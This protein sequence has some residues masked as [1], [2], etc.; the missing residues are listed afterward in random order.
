[1]SS[2]RRRRRCTCSLFFAGERSTK[3]KYFLRRVVCIGAG[4]ERR[5]RYD[6]GVEWWSQY[7]C[8]VEGWGVGV[9]LAFAVEGVGIRERV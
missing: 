7:D 3:N 6:W 2:Y 1:M 8:W 5:S 9:A 4:L